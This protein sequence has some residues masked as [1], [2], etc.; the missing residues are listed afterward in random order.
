[1]A[2]DFDYMSAGELRS[3]IARKDISPVELTRRAL[4]RAAAVQA[5]LN[6]FFVM[7]PDEA[8][9]AARAAEDAVM[10]G[11]ALGALHG[12]PMSV[13]DLI[14]VG[15]APFAFGSKVMADNIAPYDAP[16]VARAR[17]AG[18]D[19]VAVFAS[20][21]EG[22]SRAN[23]NCSIDESFARFAPVFRA[24]RAD[25]IPVRGYV[26]CVTDCPYEGRVAPAAVAAATSA[27]ARI[28]ATASP[29]RSSS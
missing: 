3:R 28:A 14:S 1:M 25:G 10:S 22:F 5:D 4:E 7:F 18:V 8:M 17:A 24:A 16:A 13:K 23:I 11:G 27:C 12:L 6:P 2:H 19:R 20:A 15:D 21:T 9:A 29:R 26:S